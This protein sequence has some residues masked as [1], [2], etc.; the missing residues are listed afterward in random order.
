MLWVRTYTP[1]W[2]TLSRW[3]IFDREGR[4]VGSVDLP[5][6]LEVHQIGK[7][8]VLGKRIDDLGVEYIQLHNV[9]VRR[10]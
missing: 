4:W 5:E 7:D 9:R 2:E 6:G 3:R 10:D 1:P 8:H